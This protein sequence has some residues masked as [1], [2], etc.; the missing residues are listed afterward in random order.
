MK[1]K[2]IEVIIETILWILLVICMICFLLPIG[3]IFGVIGIV[4]KFL[5]INFAAEFSAK[6]LDMLADFINFVTRRRV[7]RFFAVKF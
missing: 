4:C 3:A 2:K 5:H 1:L 7:E 6:I